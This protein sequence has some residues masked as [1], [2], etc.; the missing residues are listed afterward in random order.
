MS[1]HRLRVRQ[2]REGAAG[3]AQLTCA[4]CP[5]NVHLRTTPAWV[6]ADVVVLAALWHEGRVLAGADARDGA[7]D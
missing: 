6:C 7:A 1:G 4:D 3:Y 2:W 5:A